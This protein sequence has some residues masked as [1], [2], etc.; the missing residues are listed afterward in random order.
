MRALLFM[1]KNMQWVTDN[2]SR[3]LF[4]WRYQQTD[5]LK[6]KGILIEVKKRK[7]NICWLWKRKSESLLLINTQAAPDVRI[8]G[9]SGG[10]RQKYE[11]N[12]RIR[13]VWGHAPGK[14]FSLMQNAANWAIFLIFVRPFG[15]GMAPPWSRLWNVCLNMKVKTH[16]RFKVCIYNV[17][18]F[19]ENYMYLWHVTCS[20]K[21]F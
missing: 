13:E 3:Y 21:I 10:E 11:V 14:I 5:N 20:I 19:T 7:V 12:S 17:N 2:L 16:T 18:P 8:A 4:H 15:R 9:A 6:K 1:I